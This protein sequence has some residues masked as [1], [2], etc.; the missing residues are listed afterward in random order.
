MNRRSLEMFSGDS[1]LLNITV[2]LRDGSL[3]DL[4][5]A[6]LTYAVAKNP[7]SEVLLTKTNS[8]GISVT[9]NGTMQIQFDPEDTEDID[10]DDYY[11]EL[12]SVSPAGAK[13]TLMFGTLTINDNLT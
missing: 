3:A 7:R 12:R 13:T 10:G 5:G 1:V 11:H 9:G 8:D 2:R 6:T 4:V